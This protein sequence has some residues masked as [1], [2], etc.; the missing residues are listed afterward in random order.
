M[1]INNVQHL[2]IEPM[3]AGILFG[4]VALTSSYISVAQSSFQIMDESGNDV[5]SQVFMATH[6][7]TPNV[8]DALFTVK[9]NSTSSLNVGMRRYEVQVVPNT[10]NY[11]CWSTCYIAKL[12]GVKPVWEDP[13]TV[14]IGANSSVTL[15]HAFH[16]SQGIPGLATFR[17]VVFDSANPSDSAFVDVHFDIQTAIADVDDFNP[18]FTLFPNPATG[19][20]FAS[21]NPNQIVTAQ[22][23]IRNMLGD[24]VKNIPLE[25]SF[26][27][28]PIDI[29]DLNAGVYFYSIM[30]NDK[31]LETKRLV[32]K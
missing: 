5:T 30:V 14:A 6:T 25:E 29:A 11:F 4:I 32:I 2:K 26:T 7:S 21:Y 13:V 23:L 8:Y 16:D 17:Y 9:N 10:K 12:A 20:V 3:K 24:A 27:K 31:A 28:K 15:M 18:D 1:K 22:L 19:K